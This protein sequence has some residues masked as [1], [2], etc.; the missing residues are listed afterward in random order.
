MD[1]FTQMTEL[2]KK[3]RQNMEDFNTRVQDE[4]VKVWERNIATAKDCF[5][6]GMK[7]GQVLVSESLNTTM[8]IKDAWTETFSAFTKTFETPATP[9]AT[10]KVK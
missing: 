5:E 3:T 9:A 7:Q 8:M 2:M 1:S 6:V 4:S 10:A